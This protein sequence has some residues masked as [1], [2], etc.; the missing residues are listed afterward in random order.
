MRYFNMGITVKKGVKEKPV[1]YGGQAAMEG[2]MMRGRKSYALAVRGPDKDIKMML[3]SVKTADQRPKILRWPI[4]R[5][6]VAF[7]AS[8]VLGVKIIQDSAK[9]AGLD[10]LA[11]ENPSR[12]EK[13]LE[14]RFGDKLFNYMM[15]FS[16]VLA[17][18]LSIGLFMLLPVWLSSF[19]NPIIGERTWILGISEGLLR[20]LILIGYLL[21]ISRMKEIQRLF[22]Y[23]GA[24][25]KA[26]NCHESGHELNVEN[27]RKHTCLHKRCGTSF[28][29][30]V[31]LISMVVFFFVR[32]DSIWL[33]LLS[34]VILV[35]LVAG[36]SYEFIMWAGRSKSKIVGIFSA[37]GMALQNITT[38]EPEDDQIEIAIAALKGVLVDDGV[39]PAP[40][41][42][43]EPDCEPEADTEM[44]ITPEPG[45]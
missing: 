43:S 36:L 3:Q 39:I 26:I 10:D 25:H 2:V 1:Y 28:L 9:M 23:H 19:L 27:V 41:P 5:G 13:W 17:L 14:K 22:Q 29:L 11:E 21:L 30:I 15:Y 44:D 37:P 31:M 12:F 34:R 24:E 18:G 42:E 16:V 40:E 32:V 35:P 45:S 6:I 33:R 8:L 4:M 38:V 20:I 7:G